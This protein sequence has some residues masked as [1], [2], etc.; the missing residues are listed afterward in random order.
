MPATTADRSLAVQQ[1]LPA[2]LS[3]RYDEPG[4]LRDLRRS[5]W[6][7]H[8]ATPMP[9][10]SEEE[11]RRVNLSG[12]PLEAE[13][14]L[15]AIEASGQPSAGD[16]GAEPGAAGVLTMHDGAEL[17][18]RVEERWAGAGVIFTDLA[19]AVREHPDL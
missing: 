11:W 9:T 2:R 5:W 14:L 13:L 1:G 15:P 17:A 8:E 3:D 7:R 10:G 16:E 18:N 19:T 6:E 4:W 12:L